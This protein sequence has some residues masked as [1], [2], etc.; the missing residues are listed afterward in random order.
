MVAEGWW[1]AAGGCMPCAQR[2]CSRRTCAQARRQPDR[3][4]QPPPDAG[5]TW[6]SRRQPVLAPPTLCAAQTVP[7]LTDRSASGAA[8]S[9][10]QSGGA[11]RIYSSVCRVCMHR[12]GRRR[13]RG[14]RPAFT[15]RMS[16]PAICP[17]VADMCTCPP[18]TRL[19]PGC[20]APGQACPIGLQPAGPAPATHMQRRLGGGAPVQGVCHHQ[21]HGARAPRAVKHADVGAQ[22]AGGDGRCGAG[23]IEGRALGAGDGPAVAAVVALPGEWRWAVGPRAAMI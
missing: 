8:M 17:H 9:S 5:P 13:G 20:V 3:P 14:R 11:G 2:T 21:R 15:V 12:Q 23:L 22:R 19:R 4:Q 10:R 6:C 7:V 16:S 18:Q 1:R